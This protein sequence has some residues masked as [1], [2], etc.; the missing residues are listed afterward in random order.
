MMAR[1]ST[2]RN[3]GKDEVLTPL[4][5]LATRLAEADLNAAAAPVDEDFAGL[6]GLVAREVEETVLP[7][8]FALT[9][10]PRDVAALTV[11]NRRLV[12]MNDDAGAVVAGPQTGAAAELFALKL[13]DLWRNA[14]GPLRLRLTGRA[15]GFSV[16]EMSCSADDLTRAAAALNDPAGAAAF[17]AGLHARAL[18][19]LVRESAEAAAQTAGDAALCEALGKLDAELSQAGSGKGSTLPQTEAQPSCAVLP[20]GPDRRIVMASEGGGLVL[21]VIASEEVDTV[22][23][24]WRRAFRA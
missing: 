5:R 8:S 9:D 7:R 6:V 18:A 15:E 1:L 11:S 14:E 12:G 17:L 3:A 4:R 16:G 22:L 20:Y 2:P 10:G 21:A 23:A 13:Q 24:E 19:L